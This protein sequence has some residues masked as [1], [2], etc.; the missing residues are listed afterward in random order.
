MFRVFFSS[1]NCFGIESSYR[2]YDSSMTLPYDDAILS[3]IDTSQSA[4]AKQAA[5]GNSRV[6]LCAVCGK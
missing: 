5:T 2:P 1:L 3:L 6:T 4:R